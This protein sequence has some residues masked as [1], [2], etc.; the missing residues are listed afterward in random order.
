M[1]ATSRFWGWVANEPPCLFELE[2]DTALPDFYVGRFTSEVAV[3]QASQSS[4]GW[5]VRRPRFRSR[6]SSARSSLGWALHDVGPSIGDFP[7]GVNVSVH[8]LESEVD[9]KYPI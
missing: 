3:V 8:N 1:G 7:S 2:A 9:G 6:L 5:A 4:Q